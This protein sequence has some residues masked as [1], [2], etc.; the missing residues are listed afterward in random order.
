MMEKASTRELGQ[1]NAIQMVQRKVP[2]QLELLKGRKLDDEELLED[3]QWLS[4]RLNEQV[5]DLTSF[6][7]YASEV[8]SAQLEWSPVHRAEKFWRENAQRLNEKNFELLKYLHL[9]LLSNL[10]FLS[11]PVLSCSISCL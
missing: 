4:E 5:Q 8:R 1:D 7:E 9:K 10:L 6:D 2:K 3:V 11:W